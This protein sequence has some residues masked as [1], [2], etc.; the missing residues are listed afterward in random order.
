MVP[1][2]PRSPV[3]PLEKAVPV[4]SRMRLF[5]GLDLVRSHSGNKVAEPSERPRSIREKRNHLLSNKFGTFVIQIFSTGLNASQDQAL[6][7]N[8]FSGEFNPFTSVCL[9]QK[10]T[11]WSLSLPWPFN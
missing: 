6:C 4:V 9:P 7:I 11:H 5:W 8:W 1:T 2:L 3:K 10:A